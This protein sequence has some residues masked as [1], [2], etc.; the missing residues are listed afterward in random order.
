V[1]DLEPGLVSVVVPIYNVEPFLR[2]CL[3]SIRAQTYAGLQV[4]LVD[5]G[6]TDGSAAIAEQFVRDDPR[7]QLIRQENGGLSA[8]RN[9]GLE[10]ATGEYIAFVDSDDVLAAHAYEL[11]VL[12]LAGGADFA[13]G[14]VLRLNSRGTYKG[15][16]H[17]EAIKATDLNAHVSRNHGLLRDRTIWNKLFRRAF[18]DEN[19][20]EFPVG[21]LFEDVPVTVPAHAVARKVAMVAEPIYFWRAREGAVRSITQSDNDLRNLVD[22]FHTVNLT[23]ALLADAGHRDLRRAYEEQA[24]WDKLNG[25]LTFLPA[26]SPQF[27]AAFM[28]LATAYLDELDAGAVQRLPRAVRAQWQLIRDGRLDDLIELIDAGF[29]PGVAAVAKRP[30]LAATVRSV[31]WRDGK[32]RVTGTI[33]VHGA[34]SRGF[35]LS[36]VFWLA[37]SGSRRHTPLWAAGDRAGGDGQAGSGFAITVD[38]AALR[39]RKAWHDGSWRLAVAELVDRRLRRASLKVPDGWA[40]QLERRSVAPGVWIIPHLTQNQL[41]L[42]VSKVVAWLIDSHRDGDDLVLEGRFREVP[43]GPVRL[44]LRRARGLVARTAP[45]E[46]VEGPDG[47]G[48]RA[49]VPL[50]GIALDVDDD[51][52][53]MGLYAQRF[54][55]DLVIG[56]KPVNLVAGEDYQPSRTATGADEVYVAVSATGKVSVCTRPLG[57]VVTT[58]SWRPD[59]V[60]LLGGESA[61]AA[62]GDLMLRLRGRR[63]DLVLPLRVTGGRWAVEIDSEA[64][65]GLAGRLPMVAGTWDLAFRTAGRH[66]TT[67]APLGFAGEALAGLPLSSTAADG[68]VRVLRAAPNE[69]AILFVGAAEVGSPEAPGSADLREPVLRD[70]VLFD[71]AAGRRLADDPAALLAELGGRPDAPTAFWTTERSQPVPAGAE[72]VTLGTDGWRAALANCRWIVTNDD[73]PRWFQPRDAQV[74]LRLAGGWPITHIGAE[75]VA[76]PLGRTLVEQLAADAGKWT[77]LAS[78][79][80]SATSVLRRE[81]R[82]DGPVL[83]YGR[84]ADD[85]LGAMRPDAARAEVARRLGLSAGTRFILY[86]PTRR[87][88]ELRK[89][90]ASDPSRLLNLS[91][92]TNA[93]P[94]HCRLL[95]RRHPALDQDVL[96]VVEGSVDVSEYQQV[97]E[98]LLAADALITDY[99]SLIADFV[100]TGKPL[101]LY[102]PDLAEHAASPGLNV[103]LEKVAPGPLLRTSEEV[104]AALRDLPAIAA[105]HE[106]A[107]KAFAA[108]HP[109]GGEGSAASAK[110]VDWLLAARDGDVGSGSTRP[111]DRRT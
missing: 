82:Y 101:L 65:A 57:P 86:A 106:G 25:Y 8:A 108:A 30:P 2:D 84:P 99:S 40:E 42:S 52:H 77:A 5:D 12:A 75:A 15:G 36:R 19:G 55:V 10:A 1:A 96:G 45:I 32:L 83:E 67:I 26:A 63:K 60:L 59:G 94:E 16:P 72:P 22:R 9:N 85:V 48:F 54:A 73:L 87:P 93:L 89:R 97:G 11:L 41:R 35:G 64:V 53:A 74:V 102:V 56:E 31:A 98:L 100:A 104:A 47:P 58:A 107:A 71:A 6:S 51:N 3:D 81:F 69:R 76:H 20:F 33:E 68:T 34:P 80:A 92:V 43:S 105:E 50:A 18:Y 78:P 27:R 38:P 24:V 39:V 28:E 61:R 13:S 21:R 88:M 95:V 91:T 23:R 44:A 109:T 37:R 4:I 79:G 17:D 111:G 103:D 46:L 49:R 14:G 62:D 66:H 110:L 29:R 7:F 70:A 90:G